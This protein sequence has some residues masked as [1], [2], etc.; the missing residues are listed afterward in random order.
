MLCGQKDPNVKQQVLEAV[1][2]GKSNKPDVKIPDEKISDENHNECSAA[3]GASCSSSSSSSIGK[4]KKLHAPNLLVNYED[5]VIMD[6]IV[7]F[8]LQKFHRNISPS[9]EADISMLSLDSNDI[10]TF[11]QKEYSYSWDSEES[12]K[13][14]PSEDTSPISS[15]MAELN[16][17]GIQ[18]SSTTFVSQIEFLKVVYNWTQ[19]E[20]VLL[21][22]LRSDIES[23]F[24]DVKS[25][26]T[27]WNEIQKTMEKQGVKISVAQIINK[28]KNMKK[29]YKE[30][31]DANN[32]TGNNAV[33]WKHH[34][35]F[36]E[37][38]GNKA[39]TKLQA[40]YDSGLQGASAPL[41]AK[42]NEG[43][44]NIAKPSCSGIN[45]SGK[46]AKKR[47]SVELYDIIENINDNAQE[48][49]N[50]I[51]NHNE[52]QL[53]KLDRFLDLYEKSISGLLD[54]EIVLY[55]VIAAC[56]LVIL[57]LSYLVVNNRQKAKIK[58]DMC[59][60]MQ[61]IHSNRIHSLINANLSIYDE[62]DENIIVKNS[63]INMEHI[64]ERSMDDETQNNTDNT[65]YL[66]PIHSEDKSSST[67][68]SDK[69]VNKSYLFFHESDR[70]IHSDQSQGDDDTTSY[71]H[72]YHTID[73]D[74]KDKTHQ[75]DV[76]H[77]Q[78]KNSDESSVS[79]TQMITDRYLNPYQ[80]LKDDWKQLSHSYEAPV[81][82][83]QC[84]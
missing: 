60:A 77:V 9:S 73:E 7:M 25:H 20:E 65:T 62:N 67:S 83:H 39:S 26:E 14:F 28:W 22:T 70:N 69:S 35:N 30:V 42:P 56:I 24:V 68:V 55:S 13:Y 32:K 58:L 10:E 47:K 64:N 52:K 81:T 6:K 29:R 15:S 27:L 16:V 72:P 49:L 17:N 48:S 57:G 11:V 79:S 75:Y 80:P 82:V 19:S 37:L 38:Y 45:A 8:F 66:R 76:V 44:K 3:S 5:K 53:Q 41:H 18:I 43:E 12:T 31:I 21:I 36:N 51:K 50:E 74:W 1:F 33:S 46:S 40:S 2:E 63:N 34:D 54:R 59:N 61:N 71:L 23:K 78:R 4:E 84:Q